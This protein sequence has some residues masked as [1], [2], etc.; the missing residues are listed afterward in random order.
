M[1]RVAMILIGLLLAGCG[2]ATDR[3]NQIHIGRSR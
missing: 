3:Y 2:L 1:L